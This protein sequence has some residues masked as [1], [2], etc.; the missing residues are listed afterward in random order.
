MEEDYSHIL[1]ESRNRYTL[2]YSPHGTDRSKE[3]HE[4]EV[5]V[6]RAGLKVLARDGY[7]VLVAKK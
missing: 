6:A 4:I 7:F 1:E 2:A 3:F 5:K